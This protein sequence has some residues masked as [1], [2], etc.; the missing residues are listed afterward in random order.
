MNVIVIRVVGAV[1]KIELV[2]MLVYVMKALKA[3]TVK[4]KLMNAKD[5]SINISKNI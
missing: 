2:V 1:V 3:C 5:L 4:L